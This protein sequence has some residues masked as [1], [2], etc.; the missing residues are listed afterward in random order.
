MAIGELTTALNSGARHQRFWSRSR[1]GPFRSGGTFCSPV[2]PESGSWRLARWVTRKQP[3]PSGLLDQS[4]WSPPAAGPLPPSPHLCASPGATVTPLPFAVT[5][6]MKFT[7]ML[8]LLPPFQWDSFV[9]QTL[10]TSWS[11]PLRVGGQRFCPDFSLTAFPKCQLSSSFSATSFLF[12][13][14]RLHISLG[15]GEA[16]SWIIR[17]N[18]E[19]YQQAFNETLASEPGFQY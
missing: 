1:L 4:A 10:L 18:R 16:L 2:L 17:G 3:L 14:S 13:R 11:L 12:S 5:L 19:G 7:R 6:R 15:K 8:R 9:P